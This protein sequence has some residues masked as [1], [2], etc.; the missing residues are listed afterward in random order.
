MAGSVRVEYVKAICGL[1]DRFRCAHAFYRLENSD[2]TTQSS[3]ELN[4]EPS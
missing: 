2:W 1:A 3:S 4:P